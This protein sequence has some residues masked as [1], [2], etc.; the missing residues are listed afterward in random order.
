MVDLAMDSHFSMV[1]INHL[2][3]SCLLES[4]KTN[5]L[6]TPPQVEDINIAL[7]SEKIL[8]GTVEVLNQ[9]WWVQKLVFP[10]VT[11]LIDHN[12]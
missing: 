4:G 6:D 3:Q 7:F 9:R 1:S 12:N 11:D 10:T 5:I 8:G 2:G